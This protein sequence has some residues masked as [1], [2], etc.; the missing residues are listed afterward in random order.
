MLVERDGCVF[1]DSQFKNS[2]GYESLDPVAQ[3]AF[4]NHIHLDGTNREETAKRIIEAWVRE[5]MLK[6]PNSIFKIYEHRDED[7]IVIRF[8]RYRAEFPDWSHDKKLT[9]TTVCT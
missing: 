4:V 3:E 5:M 8:H 6:W 9:I 7:E 2:Y 1:D